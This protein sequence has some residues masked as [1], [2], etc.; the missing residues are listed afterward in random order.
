MF[1]RLI[2]FDIFEPEFP[3]LKFSISDLRI[4]F[5]VEK[6]LIGYPNLAEILVYNLDESHR[7]QIEEENL[8]IQLS[9]GYEDTGTPLL[10]SGASKNIVHEYIK[11]DWQTKIYAT[12]SERAINNSTINKSLPEGL[13]AD[14]IFN[15]LV[16][17]MEGVSKG[18]IQGLTNCLTG[19]KSLLRKLILSGNIKKFLKQLSDD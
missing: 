14:K 1:N 18:V 6:S 10:F 2:Q 16:N 7:N 8:P 11:P 17:E 4:S 13:T 9:A 19:K 15:E 3:I 5:K 12:D